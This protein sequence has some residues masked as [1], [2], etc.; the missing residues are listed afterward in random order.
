MVRVIDRKKITNMKNNVLSAYSD[1]H[2]SLSY[3]G[4]S[5]I[6]A[7]RGQG[8]KAGIGLTLHPKLSGAHSLTSWQYQW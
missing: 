4:L 1:T 7:S 2:M 5:R 6:L 8:V 3:L